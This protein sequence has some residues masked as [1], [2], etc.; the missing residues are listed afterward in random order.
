MREWA[1]LGKRGCEGPRKGPG[2]GELLLRAELG[3]EEV[4]RHRV[5]ALGMMTQAPSP[6]HSGLLSK[7]LSNS[8]PHG[9]QSDLPKAHIVSLPCFKVLPRLSCDGPG[10]HHLTTLTSHQ[11]VLNSAPYGS[12]SHFPKA[13][14]MSL[15]C[16]KVLPR[17]SCDLKIKPKVLLMT[18]IIRHCVTWP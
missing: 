14:I 6:Y 8:A 3:G 13:R 9:S 11:N 12:L 10:P 1:L 2:Y 17:L 16:F 7:L 4:P 15:P 5:A 18:Y